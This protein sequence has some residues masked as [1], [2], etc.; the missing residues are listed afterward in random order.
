MPSEGGQSCQVDVHIQGI[1][2]Q[3][4]PPT[5]APYFSWIEGSEYIILLFERQWNVMLRK[6]AES[7]VISCLEW[8]GTRGYVMITL[9]R[10]G[11]WSEF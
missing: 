7:Y 11:V 9:R 6:L 10:A 1:S 8:L 2:E 3:H 4:L 5:W